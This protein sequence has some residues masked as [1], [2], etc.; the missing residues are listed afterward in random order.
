M[1][2]GEVEVVDRLL[3]AGDAPRVARAS[4]AV[5]C[6]AEPGG[7]QP[8]DHRVV[9][10]PGDPLPVLDQRQLADPGVQPGVLDGHAGGGRQ[11]DDQLLVDVGEHLG[12]RSCR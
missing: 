3:D 11:R 5:P 1:L 7:E 10:V 12:A 2:H 6:S 4:R 9:Q 8:L